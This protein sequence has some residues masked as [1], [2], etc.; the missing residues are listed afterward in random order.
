MLLER[1]AIATRWA[2]SRVAPFEEFTADQPSAGGRFALCFEDL[3]VRHGFGPRGATRYRAAVFDFDGRPLGR[4]T[5]RPASGSRACLAGLVAGAQRDS[6][7]IVEIT[8]QRG[9]REVQPIYV[10]LARDRAGRLAVI[11][12]DRR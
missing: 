9:D 5:T 2:L 10:H 4:T 12:I 7:S 3:W 8:A 1:R 11:G 6:Y